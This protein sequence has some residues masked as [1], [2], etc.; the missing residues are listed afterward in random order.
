MHYS[1][2]T[3]LAH[4]NIYQ[5][6]YASGNKYIPQESDPQVAG[7]VCVCPM[8]QVML[9]T[10][11]NSRRR[12]WGKSIASGGHSLKSIPITSGLNRICKY[13]RRAP[14]G[15]NKCNKGPSA[16]SFYTLYFF[17]VLFSQQKRIVKNAANYHCAAKDKLHSPLS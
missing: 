12:L 5:P 9:I 10:K 17:V 6:G 2:G 1:L 13:Y 3:T 14:A 11:L 16:D 15:V 7:R 8:G 4:V